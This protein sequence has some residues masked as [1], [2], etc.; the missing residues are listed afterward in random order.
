MHLTQT[1][2]VL[3]PLSLLVLFLAPRR[4][5]QWAIVVSAF[6]AASVV[7]IG[8]GFAV[9][10]T[11]YFFAASL[12]AIRIGSRFL[13]G[14]LGLR[15]GEP[16][17]DHVKVLVL[18]VGWAVVSTLVL[19]I[20]FSGMPVDLGRAGADATYFNLIPLRWTFS[21]V[22][23][24]GY[25]VLDLCLVL[26]FLRN[27]ARPG[28]TEGL[29]EAFTWSGLV[30]VAVGAYQL[31]AYR[32]DLPFPKAFLYSNQVWGQLAG[33]G[34]G[35]WHRINATFPEASSA[36]DFLAMWSVFELV[37]AARGGRA[38]ARHWWFAVA[39]SFMVVNTTSTTG[40]VALGM[41]W[42]VFI[43]KYV[44]RLM[45]EGRVAVR[46]LVAASLVVGTIVVA[47]VLGGHG[48]F[49]IDAVLLNKMQTGSGVHRLASVVEGVHVFVQSFGLGVG[50]G[51]DRALSAGAYI[52]ANLG[53]VGIVLF[54]YLLWQL[55]AL[56]RRLGPGGAGE[57]KSRVWFEAMGWA[58][59]VQLLAMLES[60]AEITGP[61]LW[62]PWG[63]LAAII[64][65]DFLVSR[66]RVPAP[67]ARLEPLRTWP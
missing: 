53:V 27:A 15:A 3:I 8:G 10:I 67:L 2:V 66:S 36:G 48:A 21:N 26:L 28:Y 16:V 61:T 9:G 60:G 32:I 64:R 51:S 5:G 50:L 33:E 1:G 43:W 65:R 44:I 46:A 31:L 49:L 29:I 39:G 52:L 42:A 41:A 30:V 13:A 34:I 57:G 12:I 35:G 47:F 63:I 58:L 19:P 20:L 14:R 7:N 62:V 25:L 24:A 18:F 11:P 17:R 38:G 22:G 37:L 56:G 55:Y 54:S 23:Q 59:V 45:L 4:L 6:G 40:Y